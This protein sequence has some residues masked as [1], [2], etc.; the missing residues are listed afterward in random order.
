MSR[1]QYRKSETMLNY[2]WHNTNWWYQV[3]VMYCYH[4]KSN[5]ALFPTP[6]IKI[7]LNYRIMFIHSFSGY[8]WFQPN[9]W[10]QPNTFSPQPFSAYGS[11]SGSGTAVGAFI[12]DATGSWT[13]NTGTSSFVPATGTANPRGKTVRRS[14]SD[15]QR[16]NNKRDT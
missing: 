8:H 13:N 2:A 16:G 14:N 10:N 1:K 5:C 12:P 9:I 11:R 15:H 3:I 4:T 6:D 7:S